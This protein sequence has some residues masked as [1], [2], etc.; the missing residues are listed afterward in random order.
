MKF[1]SI[2]VRLAAYLWAGPNT[3]LGAMAGILVLGFGGRVRLVQGVAEFH[4]GLVGR[5]F[6]ALPA[7]YRFSAMTLG[8]VILGISPAA[9]EAVRSHEHVHVRQCERWGP[10]FLPAYGLSSLWQLLRGRRVYR[11][12]YFERQAF[13][14]E[15][16]ESL[17]S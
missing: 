11:D 1:F 5:F 9:L 14:E 13:A 17:L 15:E 6:A 8:H 16:G 3:L 4:G 7:G 10:L 12:N 2:G